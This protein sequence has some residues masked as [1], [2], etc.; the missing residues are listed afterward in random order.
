MRPKGLEL[1]KTDDLEG[2]RIELGGK[3][4]ALW[5]EVKQRLGSKMCGFVKVLDISAKLNFCVPP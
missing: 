2:S 5:G 3:G 1:R 4:G